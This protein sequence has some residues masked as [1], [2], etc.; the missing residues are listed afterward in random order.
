M[1]PIRNWKR[2]FIALGAAF[3]ITGCKSCDNT[4]SGGYASPTPAPRAVFGR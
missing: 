4:S 1:A 2:I 3:L